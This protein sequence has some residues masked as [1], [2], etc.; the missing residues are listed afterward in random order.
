MK[1]LA[2]F[3]LLTVVS[4]CGADNLLCQYY[5]EDTK[6]YEKYCEHYRRSLPQT[7]SNVQISLNASDVVHLRIEGCGPDTLTNAS[8]QFQDIESLDISYSGYKSLSL[9]SEEFK[10]LR[11]LEASHNE[12]SIISGGL[13]QK[14]PELESLDLSRNYLMAVAKSDFD[15]VRKLKSV[16]FSHNILESMNGD[17]FANLTELQIIRLDNNRLSN[18][19]VFSANQN[20]KELHLE[21]NQQITTFNCTFLS[22]MSS[23]AVYLSWKHVTSFNGNQ[24]CEGKQFRVVANSEFEGIIPTSDGTY[25]FHCNDQSFQN[26]QNFVAGR[27][28]FENINDLLNLLTPTTQK[29]DLSGNHIGELN[30]TAFERFW[31]LRELSLSDTDLTDFDF[32][33]LNVKNQKYLTH[34]DISKNNLKE[35]KS[36]VLLKYFGGLYAFNAAGN[37]IENLEEVIGYLSST[38]Q[39]LNLSGNPVKNL[40]Q[41]TFAKFISLRDLI[42]SDTDLIIDEFNP[43]E[44]LRSLSNLDIS[45]NNLSNVNF[46]MLSNSLEQLQNFSAAD[47]QIKNVSEVVKYLGPFVEKLDLSGNEAGVLSPAS[48]DGLSNLY[49]LNL[50]RT[51]ISNFDPKIL[52]NFT[53]LSSLDLSH[54][55]LKEIDLGLLPSKLK[56]LNLEGNDLEKIENLNRTKFSALKSLAV[57]ENEL[58]CDYLEQLQQDFKDLDFDGDLFQQKNGHCHSNLWIIIGIVVAVIVAIL[59]IV[60]IIC[61]VRKRCCRNHDNYDI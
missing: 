46:A 27:N 61:V 25:E 44:H 42:L 17:V 7:C 37:E 43:F 10:N 5:S 49:E 16:N 24:D 21:E 30:A 9:T 20:L 55:Q 47:C 2:I 40:N 6:T 12:I 19:P 35:V 41:N 15:N 31:N 45:H 8:S 1:C 32:S 22:S 56:R 4:L 33:V 53:T 23:V 39:K 38:V 60:C 59:L 26:L 13:L 34:L 50:S 58:P 11:L 14:V 54:N 29:I 18:I 28:A 48:F 51:E 3:V 57:S 52:E 36:A